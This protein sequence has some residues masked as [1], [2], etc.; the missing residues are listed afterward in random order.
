MV[1][2]DNKGN[3]VNLDSVVQQFDNIRPT[4]VNVHEMNGVL[5]KTARQVS[6]L[7]H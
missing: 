1:I 5:I 3:V 6:Q 2:S 7:L 4:G